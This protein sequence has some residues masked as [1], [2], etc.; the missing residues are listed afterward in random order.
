MIIIG[1]AS[2]QLVLLSFTFAVIAL[3]L[4]LSGV[5]LDVIYPGTFVARNLKI[6]YIVSVF[7]FIAAV[8]MF[9]RFLRIKITPKSYKQVLL[10]VLLAVISGLVIS[11]TLKNYQKRR[12]LAVMAP[13]FDPLGGGYNVLQ[14]KIAIGS[15]QITGR[16]LFHG[17]QSQLGFIPDQH[18]DFIFAVLSEEG[19][20]V[21][22]MGILLLYVILIARGL[23]IAK[24]AAD[25]FGS[26]IAVG[27]VIMFSFY[28]IL[29]LGMLTGIM[30]VAGVPL[31]FLSYGGSSLIINMSA[32]GILINIHI[33]RYAY[34]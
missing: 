28:I 4:P 11:G 22:S 8:V 29:N 1:G 9:F 6:I 33:R 31:P 34:T 10:I 12:I 21:V 7:A 32:I 30:P 16:G 17:T 26:L 15:G 18:T 20:A 14:S 24:N 19:G 13:S 3:G 23:S 27:I 2:Q 5:Y 25:K